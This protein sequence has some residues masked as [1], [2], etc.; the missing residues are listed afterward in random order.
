MI[1]VLAGVERN[2]KNA[3]KNEFTKGDLYEYKRGEINER[4]S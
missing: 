1:P 3:V 2:I 4:Y